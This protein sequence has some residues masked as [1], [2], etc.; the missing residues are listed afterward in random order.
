MCNVGGKDCSVFY[1]SFP[2]VLFGNTNTKNKSPILKLAKFLT[3]D[4][5]PVK[6]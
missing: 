2:K 1:G 6:K 3:L 4:R 5:L